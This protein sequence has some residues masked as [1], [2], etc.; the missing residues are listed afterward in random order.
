MAAP[1]SQSEGGQDGGAPEAHPGVVYAMLLQPKSSQYRRPYHQYRCIMSHSARGAYGWKHHASGTT[2]S[3]NGTESFW[4]LF[5]ESVNSTH[6]HIGQTNLD[7]YLGEFSFRSNFRQVRNAVTVGALITL[8][9][10]FRT[11][12]DQLG[13]RR[14]TLV[15]R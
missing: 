13:Q 9:S 1:G 11:A 2:F 5:K 12:A 6:I 7:R 10:N 3:T 4:K 14:T 8:E 15:R